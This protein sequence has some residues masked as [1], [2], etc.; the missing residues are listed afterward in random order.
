MTGGQPHPGLPVDG[1]GWEA[2][3]VSIENI[4][5]AVGVRFIRKINPMNI[6]KSGEIFK[7]ALEFN[8]VAVVISQY[9]CMLIKRSH[10]AKGYLEV[11]Q[12]KCDNCAVCIEDLACTAIYKDDE[13]SVQIDNK[14]CN[15]CNVCV[16]VCPEKAIGVKK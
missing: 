5:K 8:G 11:K 16:Q 13:G 9:P 14:L 3:E 7:E 2:P 1:M 4:V 15:G 12:D 10:K 6:K